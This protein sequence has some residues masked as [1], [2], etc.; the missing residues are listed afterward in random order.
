M[1]HSLADLFVITESDSVWDG[2]LTVSNLLDIV[3]RG[4]AGSASYD[5]DESRRQIS[6]IHKIAENHSIDKEMRCECGLSD[7]EHSLLKRKI[8]T[9]YQLQ[10]QN[11]KHLL[12]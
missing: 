8:M 9:F 1:L 5:F 4:Q 11:L 2:W 3:E 10:V 7:A 6:E 12:A